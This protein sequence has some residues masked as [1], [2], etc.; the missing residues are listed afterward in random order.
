MCP[1]QNLL[2]ANG[3]KGCKRQ[4]RITYENGP[5]EVNIF[6]ERFLDS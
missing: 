6:A 3:M 4:R 2:Q 1:V 5:S